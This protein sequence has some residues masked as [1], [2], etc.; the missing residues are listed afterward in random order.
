MSTRKTTVFYVLL[1]AVASFAVALVH[2]VALRDDAVLV[3][4][5]ASTVPSMNSAP[6]SGPI[7]ALDIQQ[8]REGAVAD[9]RQHSDRDAHADAGSVRTSSAGGGGAPDDFFRRFF[10]PGG[11]GG[12]GGPEAG[13][14]RPGARATKRR[15][16][17]EQKTQAAG[18]GFVI[19][20]KDG[21]ILTNNHVVDD[22]TKIEVQFLGDEDD[23]TY[24]AKVIGKD[25]LTDSALIQLIDTPESSARGS[26]VRRLGAD[27]RGRLGHGDWQ[28][29]RLRAYG[30]GGRH[31]RNRL[32]RS[33][34]SPGDPMR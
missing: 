11:G 32:G 25:A 21:F 6:I 14:S 3:G 17:S 1:S 12:P 7:D 28:S 9:G 22:A 29:V 24:A 31:Q 27:G 30:D 20:A 15:R 16:P 33:T 19:G 23:D 5:N 10:G 34:Q 18:T 8:H 26:E 4:T 13:R 2:R